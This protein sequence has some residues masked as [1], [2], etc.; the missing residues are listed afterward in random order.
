MRGLFLLGKMQIFKALGI[1]K[2]QYAA[3]MAYVQKKVIQELEKLKKIF[4]WNSSTVKI[5]HSTLV[6]EYED[7]GIKNVDIEARLKATRLTW[8]C[9]L[10]D[11][12]HYAWKIIPTNYLALPNGDFIFHRNSISNQSLTM[13]VKQLP[14]FYE[15]LVKYWEEISCFQPSS[16]DLILSESIRLN[17]FVSIEKSL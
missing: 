1:S 9:R 6:N 17:R 3:S 11:D 4:L 7:G 13:K 5:K 14:V 12:N 16:P 8:V 10:C 2:I 15:E